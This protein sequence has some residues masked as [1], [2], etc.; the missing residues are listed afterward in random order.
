M[1]VVKSN[2]LID[3]GYSLPAREQLFLLHIISQIALDDFDFKVYS[4]HW[5]EVQKKMNFDSK[6]RLTDKQ[7]V[8]EMF[9]V[10]NGNSIKWN[11]GTKTNATPWFTRFSYDMETDVYEFIL[12]DELKPY[13]LQ[14]KEKFTKY[15][16]KYLVYLKSNDIRMYE[17]LKRHQ[18]QKE[19]VLTVDELR[20][21]LGLVGSIYRSGVKKHMDKYGNVTDLRRYV[22]NKAQK[23]LKKY[24][25]IRF[26]YEIESKEGKNIKSFRFFIFANE[27]EIKLETPKLFSANAKLKA[28]PNQLDI[29]KA[30]KIQNLSFKEKLARLTFQQMRAYEYLADKSVNKTFLLDSVFPDPAMGHER[31]RGYE[32]VFFKICFEYIEKHS[33]AKS[34]AAAFVSWWKK[35]LI[36]TPE[37]LAQLVDRLINWQYTIADEEKD[38]RREAQDMPHDEYRKLQKSRNVNNKTKSKKT[39]QGFSTIADSLGKIKEEM[40]Q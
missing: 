5:K 34:T 30:N 16:L 12:N 33:K 3:T 38:A 9:D 21:L 20:F 18:F 11:E 1:P 14:L 4:F 39:R 8:F 2:Q 23:Q 17:L 31:I 36:T 13:L 25:D 24:T 6:I 35:G 15:H 26:E 22:I 28:D 37:K 29:F 19:F 10:I 32:D 27:P 40:D 7:E